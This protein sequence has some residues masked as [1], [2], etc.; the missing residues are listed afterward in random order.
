MKGG[1]PN[2]LA[3][4]VKAGFMGRKSSKGL[5]VYEKGSKRKEINHEFTDIVKN[6]YQLVS[7]GA[8][9]NED[10]QMRMVSR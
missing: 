6:K 5:Y 9:S 3:D 8:N 10:M 2:L 7:K 1:D 4:V